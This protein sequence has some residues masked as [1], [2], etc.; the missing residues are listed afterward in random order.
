MRLVEWQVGFGHRYPG[1][2]SHG[3]FIETLREKMEAHLNEVYRQDFNITF[4]NEQTPC[5]NL[6]GVKK[7]EGH[8]RQGPLLVGA[9][10]DTRARADNDSDPCLREEPILGANDGGS[11][12]AVLLHLLPVIAKTRLSRDLQIVFFDA[13]DVGEIDGL[14]FAEGAH[15]LI[16]HPLPRTPEEVLVLDMVGGRNPIFDLDLH[17]FEN[18]KSRQFAAMLF[19]LSREKKFQPL[20]LDKPGKNK[21]IIADH[22]PFHEQGIASFVLIDID[23]PQWHTH[24]DLPEAMSKESLAL[25]EDFLISLLEKYRTD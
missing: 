9:H 2:P 12:I 14:R 23:Y 8:T 3:R 4:K 1:A 11:G 15:Y 22:Y 19:A 5:A 18:E 6:I 10:F 24:K 20:L 17:I 7:A 13:E 25:V 16:R 21:Y